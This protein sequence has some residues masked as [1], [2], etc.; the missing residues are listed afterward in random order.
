MDLYG[1]IFHQIKIDY[2]SEYGINSNP[3]CL[4]FDRYCFA[5]AVV[6]CA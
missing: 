6:G 4:N 1:N 3:T 5:F 2:K